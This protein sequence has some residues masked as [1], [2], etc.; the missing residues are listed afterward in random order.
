MFG[1]VSVL[2]ASG[3]GQKPCCGC[4]KVAQKERSDCVFG[5]RMSDSCSWSWP[6]ARIA[7]SFGPAGNMRQTSVASLSWPELLWPACQRGLLRLACKYTRHSLKCG[8]WVQATSELRGTRVTGQLLVALGIVTD[9]R[10]MSKAIGKSVRSRNMRPAAAQATRSLT[11][12]SAVWAGAELFGT[13]GALLGVATGPGAVVTSS[14]GA[15]VGGYVGL[16]ASEW[17]AR[18]IDLAN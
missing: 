7:T 16:L 10:Q 17:I 5:S 3:T 2:D 9:V 15:L 18:R 11:N 8:T 14:V 6:E 12:W 1:T 4:T 13:G